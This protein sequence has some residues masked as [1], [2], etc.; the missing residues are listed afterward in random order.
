MQKC[1]LILICCCLATGTMAAEPLTKANV[2]KQQ[3]KDT[4]LL[5][6]LWQSY[7]DNLGMMNK[8]LPALKQEKDQDKKNALISQYNRKLEQTKNILNK[9]ILTQPNALQLRQKMIEHATKYQS[10]YKL[11]AIDTQ[12]TTQQNMLSRLNSQ[13]DQLYQQM[14]QIAQSLLY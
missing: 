14:Q 9:M 1:L 2:I 11:A 10:V 5:K 3:Q 6:T 13:T 4:Q 7:Q 12:N 8:A